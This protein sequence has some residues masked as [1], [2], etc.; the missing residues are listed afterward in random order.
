MRKLLLFVMAFCVSVGNADAAVRHANSPSRTNEQNTHNRSGTTISTKNVT[1]RTT[2]QKSNITAR[3]T[4]SQSRPGLN[5]SAARAT[6][7][8]KARTATTGTQNIRTL[9][10]S[11]TNNVPTQKNRSSAR[12]GIIPTDVS[13][14]AF[15]SGYNT[16]REA[17][18]TCMDQFCATANDTYRR[19]ICSSKLTDIQSRERALAQT[20][21]QLQNFESLNLSV[22]D[23]TAQEVGAMISASEGE[24]TASIVKDKSS[25]TQALQGISDVLSKTKNKSL[26]T[27]GTLDIA[28]DINAIWAT[29]SLV[30]GTNLAN[31]T[32]ESLYNAVHAQCAD[33]VIDSCPNDSTLKMVTS[34]YGMYIESDC[35]ALINNLNKQLLTANSTIRETDRAM[36]MARLENYNAHNSSSINDCVALVRAD[37]T[38]DT[39]C[40]EDYVHCLDITGKYL[41]RDTGAPIYSASF[42]QLENQISLSGDVL[43]NQ[44][45]HSIVAELNRKRNFAATSLDTC[46][47]ISDEVW[48]EF[49]R[50]AITEIYQGQQERVRTVK[51]ECLD[52]VN[53]CY[54]EK[55]QS[56][57]DF[58]NVKEQLLLGARLELSEQLCQEKLD[59]CSNLYGGGTHGMQELITAMNDITDQKIAKECLATL[60]DYAKD[61]CA[62]PSTDTLH[63]YP[64]ACRVYSPG[65]KKYA[66]NRLCNQLTSNESAA[67]QT[68]SQIAEKN[69]FPASGFICYA[70]K[71][72][73]ECNP[74]HYMVDSTGQPTTTPSV[75]NA[76]LPCPD[77]YICESG[78]G[79]PTLP[80]SDS[81]S[82]SSTCGTDYI[83]SL[84]HKMARYASQACV[85]PSKST[86][87]LP[88]SVLQDINVVM[89]TIRVDMKKSL[90]AECDRL[91]GMWF[92]SVREDSNA[93]TPHKKFYSDTSANTQWG[94]CATIEDDTDT[95]TTPSTDTT[96]EET[97][98]TTQTTE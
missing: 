77:G 1:A 35:T 9:S 82:I 52:V 18:F 83:G 50:Q 24:L 38:A 58:S 69:E 71:T 28:G 8:T 46:R 12:A 36:Q 92:D 72:Y 96:T 21:D 94:F 80:G 2:S 29:S 54:D 19:C 87:Q 20:S 39:A 61:L 16:C 68:Y 70:L 93:Y 30:G 4:S 91:G 17:Y 40:G 14:N 79:L 42:Y 65:E 48:D 32:G 6:I 23:K 60:K 26:S 33:L 85:R 63:A 43:S 55:S 10:R 67:T 22:I 7:G 15:G 81:N 51:N 34:A 31:L 37:I 90:A 25:S 56:L 76:C 75:G 98:D 53:A 27:Q 11:A 95:T 57:K 78:T 88:A 66:S 73:T 5:T 84:Y 47:D 44:T 59:A 89:D 86:E 97:T 74:G 41:N 45:N 62:V 3:A 13:T 64:F 49:L